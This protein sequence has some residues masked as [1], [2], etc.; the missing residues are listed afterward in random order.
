MDGSAFKRV[1]IG[2]GVAGVCCAQELAR[3]HPTSR[4]ILICEGPTVV[5][6]QVVVNSNSHTIYLIMLH[7]LYCLDIKLI[8]YYRAPGGVIGV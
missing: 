7:P 5:E 8:P 2:G 3:L 6:V 1:V 4:V